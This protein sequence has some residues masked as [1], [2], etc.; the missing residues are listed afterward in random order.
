MTSNAKQAAESQWQ[1][2]TLLDCLRLLDSLT[3]QLSLSGTL[4]PT[5]A[6]RLGLRIVHLLCHH[7]NCDPSL[8]QLLVIR[9]R[10]RSRE[11]GPP[12]VP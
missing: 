5:D 4:L 7:P 2:Q 1:Y 8:R 9:A 11:L 3:R 10:A 12:L 6:L